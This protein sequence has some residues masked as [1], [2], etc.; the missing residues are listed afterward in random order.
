MF[1]SIGDSRF[2][3]SLKKVIEML[4]EN[5][6]LIKKENGVNPRIEMEAVEFYDVFEVRTN[7]KY[8]VEESEEELKAQ[9]DDIAIENRRKVQQEIETL[10]MLKA[11]YENFN[12]GGNL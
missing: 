4:T 5:L 7:I 10:Q 9:A 2:N 1:I 11:K 3:D 8:E 6:E 12:I